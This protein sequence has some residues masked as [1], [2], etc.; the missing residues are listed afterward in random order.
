MKIKLLT[1]SSS[2]LPIEYLQ[3]NSDN[4]QVIGM[5]ITMDQDEMFD[6]LYEEDTRKALYTAFKN[7][8][9]PKTSQINMMTFYDVFKE[10]HKAGYATLYIGLTSGLSGTMNNAMLAK[11]MIEEKYENEKVEI[12]IV[13]SYAASIGLSAI[14]D[15]ALN[16]LKNGEDVETI[17]KKVEEQRLYA[18]HWFVVDDLL[19][20]KNGGRIPAATAYVGT[21]LNVKP[22]LTMNDEGKLETYS[23]VRGKKKAIKLLVTKI[24]E[25]LK[26]K[27]NTVFIGHANNEKEANVI[28]TELR[29]VGVKNHIEITCLA[30]TIA[31]HV[32]PGMV[33]AAFMGDEN[34][35]KKI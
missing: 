35:E 12:Y 18:N 31:S 5:P 6:N 26:T 32:G 21:V 3:K 4:I 19:H 17:A 2:D 8:I 25:H 29:A 11:K 22:I 14:V 9:M 24:K 23:S 7:G 10:N 28:V 13:E 1:D 27:E 33:A 16:L 15:Y 20:L 34:R 30:A